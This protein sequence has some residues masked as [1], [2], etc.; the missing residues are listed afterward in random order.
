MLRNAHGISSATGEGFLFVFKAWQQAHSRLRSQ[1]AS[2]FKRHLHIHVLRNC[3]HNTEDGQKDKPVVE[4]ISCTF[5][6]RFPII[7]IPTLLVFLLMVKQS[8][9]LS[10]I[11]MRLLRLFNQKQKYGAILVYLL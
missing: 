8:Q 10:R 2:C 1:P 7:N 11:I 4:V 9:S 6:R 5:L 3:C